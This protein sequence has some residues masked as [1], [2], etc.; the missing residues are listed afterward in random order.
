[1]VISIDASVLT[2]YYQARAGVPA[3]TSTGASS[4]TGTTAPTNPTAP[5][6]SASA[7]P[8]MTALT[9]SVLAGGRFIDPTNV[10]L[11]VPKASPDYSKLFTLYQGLN[12]L[13]G[14]ASQYTATGT[15][16]FTQSQIASRFTAGMQEVGSYIDQTKF[17]DFQLAQG[18]TTQSSS[19]QVGA[20][21]ETDT[22]TTGTIYSGDPTQPV[23]AFQGPTVFDMNVT[24][25]SGTQF[26]VHFDLSDMGSTP[27]TIGNVVNYL[28]AQLKAQGSFATFSSVRTA[29]TTRTT[30][31]GGQTVTLGTNADT[32]A[33]KFNGVSTETTSFSAPTTSPAVYV[34]AASGTTT[35]TTTPGKT[36][37]ASNGVTTTAASTTTTTSDVTQNFLKFETDPSANATS[38]SD[39]KV[40]S[41]AL[42]A[43][44][45]NARASATAPDGSVY[46]LTDVNATINGQPIKGSTDV[47]L[48]KYDSAGN[49][50]YT[51]TLGAASNASGYSLAVSADGSKVA[52]GGSV[53]GEL[54]SGD[55]GTDP[56]TADSF[57]SVFDN[58]G[59]QV[60]SQRRGSAGDDHVT[61]L[62]FG[63]DG[64][65][66]VQGVTGT[67]IGGQAE[68]GGQD[69][70]IEGLKANAAGAAQAYSPQ[71]TTQYGTALTD[72]P[73]GVVVSGSSLY[74][75]GVEAGDAVVRQYN[76]QATGAPTLAATSTSATSTAVRSPA[77]R[78][79]R[80]APSRWRAPP[81]RRSMPPPPPTAS[82]AASRPSSP[83]C[84]RTCPAVRPRP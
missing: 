57:V 20:A 68:V 73:A 7:A 41:D 84:P 1:M 77:S 29:G 32:Y 83:A 24:K 53:T 55:S 26:T 12:A 62:S 72:K 4:G 13:E 43:A 75:A 10:K 81:R 82:A 39:G 5:W 64:S 74:V 21:K 42:G 49:L 79:T 35:T 3:S 31:V 63:A 76:L 40:F 56:T 27:R 47:A 66:Y 17:S 22:Y 30:T 71:F 33:L 25:S 2:A 48:E 65:L 6:S 80:M 34:G 69:G 61:G 23:A 46:V 38:A 11:D 36:T 60:Y 78:S 9:S 14:L 52:I 59:N 18:A 67:S 70:Y 45:Q 44:V 19:T 58:E 37:T 16:T 54:D 8:Q 51:R 50:V 28:N 15:S